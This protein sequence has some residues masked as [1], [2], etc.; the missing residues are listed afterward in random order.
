[1]NESS[2]RYFPFISFF[3]SSQ[4][5]LKKIVKNKI[6]FFERKL[7]PEENTEREKKYK[8]TGLEQF[9]NGLKLLTQDALS[10]KRTLF[11]HVVETQQD[12]YPSGYP[13][14]LTDQTISGPDH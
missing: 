9:M 3:S 8:M 1:M 2:G 7:W 12:C 11:N 4:L 5:E 13:G 14:P 6:V 10:D